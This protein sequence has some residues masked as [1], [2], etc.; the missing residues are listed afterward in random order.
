M[1]ATEASDQ[2]A[3]DHQPASVRWDIKPA[4][5]LVDCGKCRLEAVVTLDWNDAEW[6]ED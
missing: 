1:T 5:I 2:P 6:G 4:S 3:C